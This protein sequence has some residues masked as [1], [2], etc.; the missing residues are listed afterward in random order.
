LD[1]KEFQSAL[2]ELDKAISLPPPFP[3]FHVLRSLNH[4]VLG[5]VEASH[6]DQD[7]AMRISPTDALVMSE[8]NL[9]IYVGTLNWADDYYRR[10]LTRDPRHA[11]ALQGYADA[12]RANLEHVRAIELYTCAIAV[13]PREARLYLGRGKSHLA[14]YDFEKAQA[15]FQQVIQL[16]DKLH[17]KRQSE[18]LL[19]NAQSNLLVE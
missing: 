10:I 11:L 6:R 17:L 7:A 1:K 14:M 16:T 2:V 18:E 5:D 3:L 4:F 15:D 12:C 13:N 9:Q 8:L 19:K